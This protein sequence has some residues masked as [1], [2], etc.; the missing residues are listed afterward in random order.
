MSKIESFKNAKAA[1]RGALIGTMV[2]P[3]MGVVAHVGAWHNAVYAPDVDD[4]VA[5]SLAN[6]FEV[7]YNINVDDRKK[8]YPISEISDDG[9]VLYD[10]TGY[11]MTPYMVYPLHVMLAIVGA[12]LAAE[13]K[14][15]KQQFALPVQYER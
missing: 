15:E 4:G 1:I 11:D 7:A 14:K 3:A 9:E 10:M 13:N 6:R 2:V 12:G 8:F 5:H